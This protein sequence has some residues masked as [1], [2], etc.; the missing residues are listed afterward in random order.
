MAEI[1]HFRQAIAE[2]P[3]DVDLRLIFADWL[4]EHAGNS[5]MTGT[6]SCVF[7]RFNSE[8]AAEEIHA[9]LLE[10]AFFT[11]KWRALIARG[12]NQSPVF[13]KLANLI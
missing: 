10:T 3:H 2:E 7:S 9:Q 6:G 4:A 13:T 5:R 11:G 12:I 8:A 1:V